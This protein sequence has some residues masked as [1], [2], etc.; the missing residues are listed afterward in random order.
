[1]KSLRVIVSVGVAA[2]IV[3][4]LLVFHVV[5]GNFFNRIL[6]SFRGITDEKFSYEAF[7]ELE[8]SYA[9]VVSSSS[10]STQPA[11]QSLYIEASVFSRYPFNDRS[12]LTIA[13]GSQDG[14]VVGMPV[15]GSDRIL[16]GQVRSVR[17]T[18]SEVQTI[19]D[20][21]W[22]SGVAIGSL[23]IR[24]ALHGGTSPKLELI[25]KDA[26]VAVGD[27]VTNISPLF[28]FR[29]LIGTVASIEEKP[30]SGATWQAATLVPYFDVG[31]LQS[32]LIVKDFP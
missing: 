1:M 30:A 19:F 17:R 20:S 25:A 10:T 2:I 11:E 27:I 15:F 5:I 16:I 23:G 6:I 9:L 12:L 13:K 4:T 8:R 28:P 32:V 14:I 3:A 26:P 31:E 7:R 24:A 18:Q 22:R 29:A 21:E